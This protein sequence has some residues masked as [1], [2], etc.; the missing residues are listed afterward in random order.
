M[1]IGQ[2]CKQEQ[3]V[4]CDIIRYE[5]GEMNDTEIVEFFQRLLDSGLC[6]RL[7]GSYARAAR[8]LLAAG[9]IRRA[10]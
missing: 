9:L 7:Q 3:G 5:D 6:W 2:K 10:A 1:T 4:V 8:N